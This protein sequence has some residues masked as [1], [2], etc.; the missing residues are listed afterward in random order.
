MTS[1]SHSQP[2]TKCSPKDT[3]LIWFKEN[4]ARPKTRIYYDIKRM[5]CQFKPILLMHPMIIH[6]SDMST[7]SCSR[8][9]KLIIWSHKV[10]GSHWMLVWNWPQHMPLI[11]SNI[12]WCLVSSSLIF[13]INST[14]TKLTMSS[15]KASKGS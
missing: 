8:I 9:L 1:S 2:I 10:I 13:T 12:S 7:H 5:Y 6:Y 3:Y 14:N 11:S 15:K 4:V